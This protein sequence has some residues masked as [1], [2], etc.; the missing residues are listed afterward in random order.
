MRAS[1]AA[2]RTL[3]RIPCRTSGRGAH[4]KSRRIGGKG[5]VFAATLLV[6]GAC[7]FQV[8]T[9]ASL[10]STIAG[11]PARSFLEKIPDAPM[12]VAYEGVRHVSLRHDQEGVQTVLEYDERVLSDG[13]GHFAIVPLE[14]NAPSM[15]PEQAQFFAL[16]QERRD[17]FFYRYRD[18]RIRDLDLFLQNWRVQDTGLVEAVAGRECAV[19]TIRRI[20]D[21][22]AEYRAWIDPRTG[23]VMRAEET[24]STGAVIGRV[25]FESFT[26]EPDLSGTNLHGDRNPGVTFDPRAKDGPVEFDV[27]TPRL[28]PQGYRFEG[29]EAIDD[30]AN[31]WA[32]MVFGDGVD[33]I[34]FL[35]T[36]TSAPAGHASFGEIDVGPRSVRVFRVGP[37]T[38]VQGR[39]DEMG[40]IIVG[41]TGADALLR[42]LK[43]AIR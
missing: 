14:I 24:D 1:L 37:W 3:C 26:L 29:A 28:L 33:Q 27:W 15:T 7:G 4:G 19:L 16:L 6:L 18:F 20:R 12:T 31:R 21:G 2:R 41:K 22:V 10:P 17:G 34:F 40:V 8:G 5:R 42:M 36:K 25:E 38:L 13:Q 11:L 30:G 43:S 39:F 32:R 35:Q 9:P 23:L